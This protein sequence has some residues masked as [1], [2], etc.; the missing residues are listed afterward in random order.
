MSDL[1]H[2]DPQLRAQVH[3]HAI[4]LLLVCQIAAGAVTRPHGGHHPA[5]GVVGVR[6]AIA[7]DG[8]ACDKPLPQSIMG[9]A[10]CE[11]VPD[12][13]VEGD[14]AILQRF[15]AFLNER[16]QEAWARPCNMALDKH[17]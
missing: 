7:A 17:G 6:K 4:R 3:V 1:A 14:P 15:A 9:T 16:Q 12:G 11:A 10:H 5:L 2:I 8:E 13:A